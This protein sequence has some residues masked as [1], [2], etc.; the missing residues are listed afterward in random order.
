MLGRKRDCIAEARAIS[1][2]VLFYKEGI[3]EIHFRVKPTYTH[4]L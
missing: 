4:C 1:R 3:L 2:S